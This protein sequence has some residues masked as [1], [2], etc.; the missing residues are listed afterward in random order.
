MGGRAVQ[1]AGSE[2]AQA[3]VAQRRVLYILHGSYIAA[4][5]PEQV[6]YLIQYTEAVEVIEDHA[7]HEILGAEVICPA[8]VLVLSAGLAPVIRYSI[9]DGVGK[10]L[11][12]LRGAGFHQ[13]Y[14]VVAPEFL[15]HSAYDHC[16]FHHIALYLLKMF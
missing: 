6:P 8:H 3:S 16:S 9:H 2:T 15:L 10:R 12:Y 5:C 13:L 7:A 1:E 4:T 14:L 11:M